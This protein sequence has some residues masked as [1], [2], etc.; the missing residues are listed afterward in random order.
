MYVRMY[1]WYVCMYIMCE[2]THGMYTD[3]RHFICTCI[4]EI[5]TNGLNTILCNIDSD[6]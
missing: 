3:G 4:F 2:G 1:V 5:M 6:A